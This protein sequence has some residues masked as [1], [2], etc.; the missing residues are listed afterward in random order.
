MS[1]QINFLHAFL[2]M[3]RLLLLL[4]IISLLPSAKATYLLVPMDET[5]RNHLKA[6]GIAYYALE[7]DVEVT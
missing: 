5:Q 6:Y 4:L 2:N 3:K 1:V 7:R